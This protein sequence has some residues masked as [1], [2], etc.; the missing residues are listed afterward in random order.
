MSDF[1]D[2]FIWKIMITRKDDSV[3]IV[4]KNCKKF[5]RLE[6]NSSKNEDLTY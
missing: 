4:R 5:S 1:I 2:M 3:E 6:L